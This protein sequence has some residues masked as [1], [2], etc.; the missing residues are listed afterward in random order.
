MS[1]AWPVTPG[2]RTG[3]IDIGSNSI[4]L[5]V[6]DGLNR[7]PLPIINH[8]AVIGLGVDVERLG[9]LGVEAFRR[10]VEAVDVLVRVARSVPV[11][12]LALYAT[13]A[14]RDAANGSDFCRSIESRTGY[15]VNVLSGDG[16]A[17][18]SALGVI[19][20]VPG[21]TGVVGD[22]GGGSLELVAVRRGVI[23]ERS[24]LGI[25][26]LRMMEKWGANPGD[27]ESPIAEAFDTVA[28][29]ADWKCHCFHA[30]GGSWR[31][32][33][34]L[35]IAQHDYP[36]KIVHGYSMTRSGTRDFAGM[37][38][39]L[40]HETISRIRTISRR[41]AS[42]LPWG[43][44]VLGHLMRILKP[45]AVIFSAHGLR[46]GHHFDMLEP[47]IRAEDPLLAA[48]RELADRHRRFP[49]C[50]AALEQWLRPVSTR[51]NHAEE[52]VVR[53]ACILADTGWREHPE[54][55]ALRSLSRVLHMPWSVLDHNQ[56]AWL[57]LALF[58]RYGGS[59]SGDEALP[60]HRLLEPEC[61]AEARILG[62]MLRLALELC[63]GRG[64]VLKSTPVTAAGKGFHLE[65]MADAAVA[66]LERIERYVASAGR[67]L[68]TPFT[69][70]RHDVTLTDE[71]PPPLEPL[72]AT[73]GS[74]PR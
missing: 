46:E 8:K 31:A 10:G 15:T 61:A 72:A 57:A 48:C 74:V 3:V 40:S 42:T 24:T 11:A 16:E 58:V 34:R 68:D 18:L 19:S 5:V 47:V 73:S 9:Y 38:E 51:F 2:M 21:L 43:A 55:R 25:G 36:L 23:M 13:A 37:L 62:K 27:S 66:S 59:S 56:R 65:M 28:W 70:T 41:R 4:R 71:A 26:P 14:V 53:A 45:S 60:C 17:R 1:D 7:A 20:A 33:A 52:R 6:F 44:K 35:H 12:D 69:M 32:I 30:V 63:A 64:Q 22:L 29:L 54:Y 67:A 39:N 49:D 50:S